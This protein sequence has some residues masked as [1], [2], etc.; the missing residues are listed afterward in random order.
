MRLFRSYITGLFL[1]LSIL[2]LQVLS[3]EKTVLI[4]GANRGIGLALAEQFNN[5]GYQVIGTARKPAKADALKKLG[6]R[7]EQLDVADAKS[8]KELATRLL[9]TPIDILIN[10]AGITGHSA[11]SLATLDVEQ[12]DWVYQVNTLGPLRVT[13][14]LQPNLEQGKLKQVVDVSSMMGSMELNTWGGYI[15]YRASKAALNSFN[16]TLSVE[17]GKQGY[18]F[19]VVHPGYVQTDMN[20]G[21]GE[22][23]SQQSAQGLYKVIADLKSSDNGH[24]YDH[25]GKAMPW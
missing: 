22:I 17:L 13:Q 6:A 21:Q 1:T 15:G 16:K 10:N 14:A 4:T 12:L 23:S 9:N 20:E 25:T 3:A 7:V 18:T 24:F 2:P 8:V 5:A 19:V 11:D